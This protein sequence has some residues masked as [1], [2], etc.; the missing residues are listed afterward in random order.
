MNIKAVV[1][2]VI[3]LLFLGVILFFAVLAVGL[4]VSYGLDKL[5][6]G[7]GRNKEKQMGRVKKIKSAHDV[8]PYADGTKAMLVVTTPKRH[9]R[10]YK[11]LMK[12]ED[13]RWREYFD[14]LLIA[15][16]DPN[17]EEAF[18]AFEKKWGVKL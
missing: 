17:Q 1:A 11:R 8:I 9:S 16:G 3:L 10:E 14:D 2:G 15:Y 12:L 13:K 4:L 7:I 5:F 18:K 6:S